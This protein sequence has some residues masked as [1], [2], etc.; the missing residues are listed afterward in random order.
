MK[1]N[2]NK[3]TKLVAAPELSKAGSCA[4]FDFEAAKAITAGLNSPKL[5]IVHHSVTPRDYDKNKTQTSINNNHKARFNYKSSM[6]WYIGYHYMIFGDG[7]IRQYRKDT[8]DGAHTI[9]HNNDSIAICMVGS[10]DKGQEAPSEAQKTGLRWFLREK[11]NVF[12]I[13]IN[14]IYP[15]RSFAQKTCYGSGLSDDWARNLIINNGT[16]TI[17]NQQSSP[18]KYLL[19]GDVLIPFQTWSGYQKFVSGYNVRELTWTKAQIDAY[20]V[21]AIP[22]TDALK[23]GAKVT[24]AAMK[25]KG[26]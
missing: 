18:A 20:G 24:A 14:K 15:H 7:E 8:E 4:E 6:G 25:P 5:I 26:K 3:T 21:S 22:L 16:M 13:G 19:A 12:G 11:S 1:N 17:I 23:M 9:G 2:K 10:F